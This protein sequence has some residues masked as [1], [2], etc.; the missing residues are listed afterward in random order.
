MKPDDKKYVKK[1][2]FTIIITTIVYDILQS[3]TDFGFHIKKWYVSPIVLTIFYFASFILCFL[4][5]QFNID[6]T[7]DR[8][9][10]LFLVL[11]GLLLLGTLSQIFYK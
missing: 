6:K 11:L 8:S 2:V 10:L 4:I 3:L 9:Y 7:K 1:I 5:S